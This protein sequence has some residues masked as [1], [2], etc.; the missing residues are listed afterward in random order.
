[1]PGHQRAVVIGAEVVQVLHHEHVVDRIADLADRR[2]FAIGEDVAVYPRV[3]DAAPRVLAYRVQQRQTVRRQCAPHHLHEG[4]EVAPADVLEHA[5]AGY[6][7]EGFAAV[8]FAVVLQPELDRQSGVALLCPLRL[9][10]RYGDA[11]AAHAAVFGGV[12]EQAAPAATDVQQ[13]HAGTQV[14]LAAD[15]FELGLL[16]RREVGGVLPVAAGVGHARVQHRRVEI[17][18]EVVVAFADLPGATRRLPIQQ[19]GAEGVHQ[20]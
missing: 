14:Q 12:A 16:R 10:A 1:M 2:Q 9:F 20:Q 5:D 19:A 6:P 7:I 4:A 13:V 11:G 8:E 3:G 17:V 15:Q 18:A